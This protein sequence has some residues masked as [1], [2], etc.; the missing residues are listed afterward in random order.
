MSSLPKSA[1]PDE[2]PWWKIVFWTLAFQIAW[3]WRSLG[4]VLREGELV[5][6]DDFLRM[7]QVHN[8]LSGQGW[9]DMRAYRMFPPDGADIHWS[10]LVDCAD[11]GADLV[12]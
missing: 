4:P 12:V 6:P 5:G 9:F 10:R 11:C 3:N 2:T 7:H 1:S 8:F